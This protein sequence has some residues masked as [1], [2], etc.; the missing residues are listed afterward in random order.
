M[1]IKQNIIIVKEL[2]TIAALIPFNK[3]QPSFFNTGFDEFYNMLDDFFADSRP[4]RRSLSGDTFKLDVRDN[5][6]DFNVIAD[7]PGV[8]KDEISIALNE[9]RLSITVS[10]NEEKEDKKENYLHRERR[11]SSMTRNIYLG[12]TDSSGI[13]AKLEDGVLSIIVPK[14]EKIDTTVNVAIE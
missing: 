6:K 5:E 4:L 9:G 11:C 1:L 2:L 14:K 12:D 8:K 10:K 7:L 13:K 3:N